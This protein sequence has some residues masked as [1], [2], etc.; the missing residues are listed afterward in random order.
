MEEFTLRN[1][2]NEA[3]AEF[4]PKGGRPEYWSETLAW[5]VQDYHGSKGSVLDFAEDD[6]RVCKENDLAL[7]EV[8]SLCDEEYFSNT[9]LTDYLA[10]RLAD[11]RERNAGGEMTDIDIPMD[12]VRDMVSDFYTWHKEVLPKA[13]AAYIVRYEEK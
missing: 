13:L 4:L 5:T 9:Y 10:D 6:W 11:W 3:K 12:D 8:L 1:K 2:I 7:G